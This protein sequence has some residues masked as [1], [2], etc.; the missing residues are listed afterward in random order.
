MADAKSLRL[1]GYGLTAVT[2]LVTVLAAALVVDATLTQ[3]GSPTI[4]AA[5]R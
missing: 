4:H 5:M 2:M 1:I 3:A